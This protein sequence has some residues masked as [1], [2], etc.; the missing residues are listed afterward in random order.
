MKTIDDSTLEGICD[1]LCDD[2]SI[3]YS[4]PEEYFMK[5]KELIKRFLPTLRRNLVKLIERDNASM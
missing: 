3:P 1:E 5:R 4:S 2:I